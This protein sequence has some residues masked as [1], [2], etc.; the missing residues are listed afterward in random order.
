MLKKCS[1]FIYMYFVSTVLVL[2]EIFQQK[3]NK[4]SIQTNGESSHAIKKQTEI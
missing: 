3:V 4:M 1:N 2:I